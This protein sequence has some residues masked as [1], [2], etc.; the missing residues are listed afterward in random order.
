MA[1]SRENGFLTTQ[2][3]NKFNK[4]LAGILLTFA[5]VPMV[6]AATFG[7]YA[8]LDTNGQIHVDELGNTVALLGSASGIDLKSTGQ[9]TLYTVPAGKT[10][11]ITNVILLITSANTVAVVPV[12][13]IGKA[14]AYNEWAALTT[15]TGLDTAGK[16]LSLNNATTLM[17]HQ[18]FA[19]GEVVKLDVQT[20][21]TATTLTGTAYLYGTLI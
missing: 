11:L 16:F 12:V 14:S 2:I 17:M 1:R 9:T 18:S 8:H 3:M 13:R 7:G 19:A 15:V 21:A 20:G 6:L 4:F 5:F 10:L